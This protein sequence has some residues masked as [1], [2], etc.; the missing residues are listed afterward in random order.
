MTRF[1][2]DLGYDGT[3]F[4][5]WAAQTSLR[6]VQGTLMDAIARAL[7]DFGLPPDQV[8]VAAG[9]TDAGVHA[10]RQVAHLDVEVPDDRVTD[11]IR[12]LAGLLP[13]DIALHSL[14]PAPPAFDARFGATGRTYCY[15]IWDAASLPFLPFRLAVTILPVALDIDA[16]ASAAATLLGLRDFAPFCRPREGATTIR[17]LR[18][19]DVGRLQAPS[20]TIECWLEADAFCHSMVRSLVGAVTAVGAGQRDLDWL[21]RVAASDSRVSEVQ[22][23]PPGGLTLEDVTYPPDEELSRRAAE[24]RQRRSLTDEEAQPS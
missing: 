10:R 24:A 7:A 20:R 4:H 12:R 1:R 13:K 21:A 8:L 14:A 19:F 17:Q 9:R 11:F 18:R 15:R 6:T 5:G 2:L 3:D 22:V 23:L 16:M